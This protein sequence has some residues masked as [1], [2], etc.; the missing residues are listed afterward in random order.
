[1][2]K[3]TYTD[4]GL[5]LERLTQSLDSVVASRTVL[6][7]RLGQTLHIEPGRAAFLLPSDVPHVEAL[8]AAIAREHSGDIDLC[9]VDRDYVEVSLAGT[10]VAA[11]VQAETGMFLTVLGDR[12]ES[13][14][15]HLWQLTQ[16]QVS[17]LI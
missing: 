4:M 8:S 6:A 16:A 17:S 12:T 11:D 14:V 2:L 10:W 3:L 5:H 9:T 1:M 7:I 15:H 13:L